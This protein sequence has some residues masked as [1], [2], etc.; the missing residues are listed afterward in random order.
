MTHLGLLSTYGLRLLV[1]ITL[2][3]WIGLA[4]TAL[5]LRAWLRPQP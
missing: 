2:S 3:T 1:A 4:V 5:V